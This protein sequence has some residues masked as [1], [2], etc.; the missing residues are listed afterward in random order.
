MKMKNIMEKHHR[1]YDSKKTQFC[2]AIGGLLVSGGACTA[3]WNIARSLDETHIISTVNASPLSDQHIRAIVREENKPVI[4]ALNFVIA[5]QYQTSTAPQIE[6]AKGLS[7]LM[8]VR[9]VP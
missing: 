7:G 6:R 4:D 2:L 5:L 1:W 9:A 8:V 3:V